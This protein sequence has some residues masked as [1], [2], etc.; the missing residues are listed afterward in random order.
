MMRGLLR[1]NVDEDRKLCVKQWMMLGII[2][3]MRH[4]VELL[5]R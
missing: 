2:I 1:W 4:H 3:V 5:K